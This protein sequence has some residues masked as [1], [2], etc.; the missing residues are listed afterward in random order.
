MTRQNGMTE[1]KERKTDRQT[2]QQNR[3]GNPDAYSYSFNRMV[4]NKNVKKHIL[5]EKTSSSTNG[6]SKMDIHM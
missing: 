3:R 6:V 2:D 4:F 1:K 5:R